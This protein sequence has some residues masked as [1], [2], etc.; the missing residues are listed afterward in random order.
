MAELTVQKITD[1]KQ[2]DEVLQRISE[3]WGAL[4]YSA[5]YDELNVLVAMA[6]EWETENYP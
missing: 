1:E 4:P 3:L 6:V 5:A 2:Y